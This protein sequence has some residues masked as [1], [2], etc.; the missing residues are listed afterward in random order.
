[1]ATIKDEMDKM[2]LKMEQQFLL[3]EE[4]GGDCFN[5]IYIKIFTDEKE[6]TINNYPNMY[7]DKSKNIKITEKYI[8]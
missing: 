5:R 1:M 3:N 7:S 4:M 8:Y 6:I 2:L